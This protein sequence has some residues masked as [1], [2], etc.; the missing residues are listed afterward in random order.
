MVTDG[1][2]VTASVNGLSGEQIEG[3]LGDTYNGFK[4]TQLSNGA[5]WPKSF[6]DDTKNILKRIVNRVSKRNA[7]V[8]ETI[9][10]EPLIIKPEKPLSHKRQEKY[11]GWS[12]IEGTLDVI[13]VHARPFL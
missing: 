6:D 5:E 1:I 7:V 12:T 11:V 2:Y 8:V 4:V 3:I 9:N 10:K 13:S